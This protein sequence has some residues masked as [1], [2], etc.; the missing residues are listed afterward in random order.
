LPLTTSQERTPFSD[1]GIPTVPGRRGQLARSA[2]PAVRLPS[3]SSAVCSP[4]PAETSLCVSASSSPPP[5]CPASSCPVAD[6][7]DRLHSAAYSG[8]RSTNTT[9]L[10]R[11]ASRSSGVNLSRCS[12][13]NG[14]GS[15]AQ[16][17]GRHRAALITRSGRRQDRAGRQSALRCGRGGPQ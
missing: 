11:T 15:S 9:S 17:G 16:P 12:R 3:P 14:R 4:A 13:H 2:R 8:S 1:N 10:R 5:P 6:P 7:V